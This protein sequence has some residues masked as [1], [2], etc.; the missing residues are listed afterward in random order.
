MSIKER[1]LAVMKALE[2]EIQPPSRK[3]HHALMYSRYGSD[4]TG[5]ED[6]LALHINLDGKFHVLFLDDDDF[7]KPI[8]QLVRDIAACL[9]ATVVLS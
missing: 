1:I 8:E 9:P 2:A 4:E 3:L 7:E 5:W 6:K